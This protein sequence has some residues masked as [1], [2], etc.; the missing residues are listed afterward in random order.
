MTSLSHATNLEQLLY[1]YSRTAPNLTGR[2]KQRNPAN[3]PTTS[4]LRTTLLLNGG[5]RFRERARLSS[6]QVH[7]ARAISQTNVIREELTATRWLARLLARSRVH[8]RHSRFRTRHS[9]AIISHTRQEVESKRTSERASTRTNWRNEPADI[10]INS[11]GLSV[12]SIPRSRANSPVLEKPRQ[13]GRGPT[14]HVEGPS[15]GRRVES[16]YESFIVVPRA[17]EDRQECRSSSTGTLIASR[18]PTPWRTSR[19]CVY[20][21]R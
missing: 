12:V 10:F 3:R 14:A 7:L 16:Y 15:T 9:R 4:S 17:R 13:D 2:L 18:S 8:E 21:A 6:R 19:R 20:A 11:A 5:S 1:V